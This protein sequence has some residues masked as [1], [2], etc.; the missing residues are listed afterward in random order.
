MSRQVK[1]KA[2]EH[3]IDDST[4]SEIYSTIDPND[5]FFFVP[6]QP[7]DN[8]SFATMSWPH[9]DEGLGLKL[10]FLHLYFAGE[11]N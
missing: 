3:L 8:R 11:G 10:F 2:L 7:F 9:H 1:T 6:H 4:V 5:I